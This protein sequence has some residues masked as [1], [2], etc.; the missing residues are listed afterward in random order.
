MAVAHNL[1]QNPDVVVVGSVNRDLTCYLHRWPAVGET[2]TAQDTRFGT[3]GKGANQAAAATRMGSRTLFVGA[4]GA[5]SFG[6]DAEASL[7]G[8]GVSLALRKIKGVTTGLA[9]IDVGPDGGNII[10]LAE[11]A[12]AALDRDC[13]AGNTAAIR[14]AKVVLLQNETAVST[15]MAA[16]LCARR[17]GGV[18]IMDPAPVP[19]P[20]WSAD[21]FG[22]FD[23]LTPNATEAGLITGVTPTDLTEALRAAQI[24]AKQ[25]RIGAIVTM[26]A[27]GVAWALEGS[28]GTM[29]CPVVAAL[30]TVAAGDCFNGA[31]AAGLA[32]DMS[33]PDAI[34]FAVHAAALATTKKGATDSLP[35]RDE[36]MHSL[37][38]AKPD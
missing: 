14:S 27:K 34:A 29:A 31:F 5:D 8:I 23:I 4:I 12:N 17:G 30:D 3:G 26:G 11:G 2:L 1:N 20:M 16:A 22:H 6:R 38:Q 37:A 28:T 24:L 18:V 25:T 21:V 15:A 33:Y 13:V 7:L 19:Q 9:F 32:Q 36:V 10:R 35:S